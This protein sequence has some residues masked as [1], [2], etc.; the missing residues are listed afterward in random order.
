MCVGRL[1]RERWSCPRTLITCL[2]HVR[3]ETRL[4]VGTKFREGWS[5]GTRLMKLATLVDISIIS[6]LNYKIL[7]LRL[8]SWV[9]AWFAYTLVAVAG[10]LDFSEDKTVHS[11]LPLGLYNRFVLQSSAVGLNRLCK[12]ATCTAF[13]IT[14]VL[15]HPS[16]ITMYVASDVVNTWLLIA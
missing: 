2:P 11:W 10:D 4:P 13:F 8:S 3:L 16:V 9:M 6:D 7:V 14:S 12:Q 5:L 15:T 1:G